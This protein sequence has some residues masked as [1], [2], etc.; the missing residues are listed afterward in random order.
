LQ[1]LD[2]QY[3]VLAGAD[4]LVVATEWKSFREPNF[5]K[6]KSLLLKPIILDGRNI[7]N[8]EE[9]KELGMQYYSIGRKD[10]NL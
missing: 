8:I 9:M 3:E 6:M 7:Y 2:D 4:I 5:E 10:F 1:F